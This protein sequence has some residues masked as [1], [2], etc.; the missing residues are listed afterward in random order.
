MDASVVFPTTVGVLLIFF[1]KQK[2]QKAVLF[3]FGRVAPRSGTLRI[4]CL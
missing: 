4:N 3:L 2:P 1:E